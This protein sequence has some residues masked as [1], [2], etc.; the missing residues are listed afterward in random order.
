MNERVGI[1]D[2]A[3]ADMDMGDDLGDG[4]ERAASLWDGGPDKGALLITAD[5]GDE[6]IELEKCAV[7]ASKE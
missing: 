2:E 4:V 6:F 7:Q 1:G 5:V 3:A